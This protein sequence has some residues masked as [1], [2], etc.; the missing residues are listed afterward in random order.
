MRRSNNNWH[1]RHNVRLKFNRRKCVGAVALITS[2]R[3]FSSRRLAIKVK[4]RLSNS[5]V[6]YSM[7]LDNLFQKYSGKQ[8]TPTGRYQA[9]SRVIIGCN[10]RQLMAVFVARL[11]MKLVLPSRK[12][13]P[14]DL[15]Q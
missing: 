11:F 7:Q 4:N 12:V 13:D 1:T 5:T 2:G 14:F 8:G 10:S 6:R 3:Q 15:V 9:L